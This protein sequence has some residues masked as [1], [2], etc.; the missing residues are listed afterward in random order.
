MIGT[1]LASVL[2]GCAAFQMPVQPAVILVRDGATSL[3]E[4]ERRLL[5]SP[6]SNDLGELEKLGYVLVQLEGASVLVVDPLAPPIGEMYQTRMLLSAFS[7]GETRKLGDA[8]ADLRRAISAIASRFGKPVEF[9]SGT[10][11]TV[12]ANAVFEF[13]VAGRTIQ[14]SVPLQVGNKSRY[15]VL[16]ELVRHP[17]KTSS[18]AERVPALQA[19][20]KWVSCQILISEAW[21]RSRRAVQL[22]KMATDAINRIAED[23]RRKRDAEVNA[24]VARL[25]ESN[26]ELL[27]IP[28]ET[29]S[30]DMIPKS[31]AETIEQT[32]QSS[33]KALGFTSE[34][35]AVRAYNGSRLS[36]GGIS[37][38]LSFSVSGMQ[39]SAPIVANIV[40][41]STTR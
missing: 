28:N 29:W 25:L 3:T 36:G 22:F 10:S 20:D 27:G 12:S 38:E 31:M 33:W 40:F 7:S 14:R 18:A 34:T 41:G 2:L 1:S 15:D 37:F 30:K 39:S 21:R 26:P 17:A 16:L 13:S 19:D 35:E 8:P 11:F 9:S 32:F 23:E 6:A 24:F 5:I 4:V